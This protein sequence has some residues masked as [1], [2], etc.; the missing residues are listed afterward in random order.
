MFIF[1]IILSFLLGFSFFSIVIWTLRNGI[2]PMPSSSKARNAILQ[3]IQENFNK[4]TEGDILELGAGFLTLAMAINKQLPGNKIVAYEISTVP[5]FFSKLLSYF[6]CNDNLTV[7]KQ[8]FFLSDFTNA[9]LIVCYLYPG[10]MAKLN[11]KFENELK[12]GAMIVSNTFAIPGLQPF[13]TLIIDDLYHTKIYL[14]K[15]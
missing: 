7:L 3:L 4:D 1:Y 13:K 9:S 14:Y 6:F 5:Y 12:S 10:S 2:S 15:I 8:D 11:A